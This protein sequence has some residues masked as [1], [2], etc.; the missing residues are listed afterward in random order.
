MS[1]VSAIRPGAC[2][3][4]APATLQTHDTF[5]LLALSA[6]ALYRVRASERPLP[7]VPSQQYEKQVARS[8]GGATDCITRLATLAG[9]C[10]SYVSTITVRP[11][12]ASCT[13]LHMPACHMCCPV[14]A[15]F[16][17][18][19][20]AGDFQVS[21]LCQLGAHAWLQQPAC[22]HTRGSA[23]RLH[24]LAVCQQ[25]TA[26]LTCFSHLHLTTLCQHMS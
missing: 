11:V 1:T 22:S 6:Y 13:L 21:F 26:S 18:P 3:H 2:L 17:I 23:G 15:A 7:D 16:T 14:S 8:A 9:S 5:L 24:A 25:A 12:P 19:P 4:I 20:C 10:P